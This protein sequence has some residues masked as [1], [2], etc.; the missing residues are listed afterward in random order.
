MPRYEYL[1]RL[2][3]RAVFGLSMPGFTVAPV[4]AEVI[5]PTIDMATG[6]VLNVGS[7]SL[8]RPYA[9][10][11]QLD[12]PGETGAITFWD[13]VL[14]LTIDAESPQDA[15]GPA[16]SLLNELLPLLSFTF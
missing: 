6:N 14:R 9:T 13:D 10:R 1:F 15:K 3:P 11:L 7:E 8:L 2:S 4:G 16:L 5:G 12:I